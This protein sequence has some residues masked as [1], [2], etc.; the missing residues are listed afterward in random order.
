M[1]LDPEIA[2]NSIMPEQ[3]ERLGGGTLFGSKRVPGAVELRRSHFD[4]IPQPLRARVLAFDWWIAN[5]D[6]VFVD[7]AGN[8]NLLYLEASN[9]LVVID[10]NLALDPSLMNGFWSEHAFR[11]D[12]DLWAPAFCQEMADRF[13]NAL[14][15]FDEIWAELPEDWTDVDCGLT[16]ASAESILWRFDRESDTFWRPL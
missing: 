10:H 9:E 1:K 8:P 11:H 6:R 5:G 7:D 2:T 13:K 4:L 14:V 12:A 16:R 15:H 3:L